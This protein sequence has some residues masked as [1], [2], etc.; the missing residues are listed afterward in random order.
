[1]RST[2]ALLVCALGIFLVALL[3]SLVLATDPPPDLRTVKKIY[4]EAMPHF[5][6]QYLRAEIGKQL[7]GRVTVVLKPEEADAILTGSS[8]QEE[9]ATSKIT[10]QYLGLHDNAAG[11]VS[12]VDKEGTKVLWSDEAGDRTLIF[13][14]LSRGGQRKVA[15]RLVRK[16]KKALGP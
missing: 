16:L 12:L 3:P 2:V 8:E 10:G 13:G 15:E 11:A 5:L 9:G 7:R 4:I 1:M 6:D 14:A